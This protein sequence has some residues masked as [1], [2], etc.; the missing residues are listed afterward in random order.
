MA[1][2]PDGRTLLLTA[3][4]RA[5]G[6]GTAPS[7]T[8]VETWDVQTAKPVGGFD[9]CVGNATSSA[10]SPDGT[11]LAVVCDGMGTT[12]ISERK[13][14]VSD[15]RTGK[16]EAS[17]AYQGIFIKSLQLSEDRSTLALSLNTMDWYAPTL[18][19]WQVKANT[20]H[21]M[22]GSG[23]VMLTP[24]GSRLMLSRSVI[25]AASGKELALMA[26]VRLVA[27]PD[28]A[29]A[30]IGSTLWGIPSARSLGTILGRATYARDGS[31]IADAGD[32]GV[33]VLDRAGRVLASFE[34]LPATLCPAGFLRGGTPACATRPA[35]AASDRSRS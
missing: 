7:Y 32:R 27:S 5:G 16:S 26:N 30:V 15:A 2:S 21:S 6:S 35:G 11:R 17:T 1:F 14:E 13:V 28:G 8:V 4:Q 12:G 34:T 10:L 25:D 19:L 18:R 23:T 31:R 33:R 22:P 9:A 3:P 24:D 29:T 20:D